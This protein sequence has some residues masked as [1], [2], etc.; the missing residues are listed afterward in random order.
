MMMMLLIMNAMWKTC[1][2]FVT[3]TSQEKGLIKDLKNFA[4]LDYW[5]LWLFK[6]EN[7][8]TKGNL[9]CFLICFI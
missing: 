4:I 5:K 1:W 2:D 9:A 6:N 3:K 8:I 7:E